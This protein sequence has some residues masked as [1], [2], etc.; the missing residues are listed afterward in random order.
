M[1]QLAEM[2]ADTLD[3]PYD[4]VS[5]LG[6]GMSKKKQWKPGDLLSTAEA[7]EVL[8][9]SRRRVAAMC[10]DGVLKSK[11]V[12]N[13]YVIEWQHVKDRLDNPPGAGRPADKP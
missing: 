7:A 4:R 2:T 3:Y 13:R 5:T 1:N 12:G 8:G 10:R 9:V 11:L 6:C